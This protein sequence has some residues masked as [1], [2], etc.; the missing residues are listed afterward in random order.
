MKVSNFFKL[1][2]KKGTA[3]TLETLSKFKNAEIFQSD[4][5]AELKRKK[6]ALNAYFRVKKELVKYKII[7][8]KI[9]RSAEKVIY[10]T[11]KGKKMWTQLLNI[12]SSLS[13]TG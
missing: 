5:L 4:F 1:F 7:S 11:D 9:D 6:N 3:I 2:R 13:A 12:E 8:F 10:L